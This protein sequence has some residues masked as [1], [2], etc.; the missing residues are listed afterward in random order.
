MKKAITILLL[1]ISSLLYSQEIIRPASAYYSANSVKNRTDI[2]RAIMDGVQ[3]W[4]DSGFVEMEI[5]LYQPMLKMRFP[6]IKVGVQKEVYYKD[7]LE[8]FDAVVYKDINKSA[9]GGWFN[10][11]K[12]YERYGQDEYLVDIEELPNQPTRYV[13]DSVRSQDSLSVVRQYFFTKHWL[14][15]KREHNNL[16]SLKITKFTEFDYEPGTAYFNNHRIVGTDTLRRHSQSHYKKYY[17][18]RAKDTTFNTIDTLSIY[19]NPLM[20]LP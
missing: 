11:R 12:H 7:T 13:L 1:L 19:D 18:V 4:K 17:Q 20:K 9:Y 3:I 14:F 6:E 15:S 8:R 16:D 2:T 10:L 5:P